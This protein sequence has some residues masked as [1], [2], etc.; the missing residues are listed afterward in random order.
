MICSP[1][2]ACASLRRSPVCE[3][4]SWRGQWPSRRLKI[5]T[6]LRS[7]S[8]TI[9]LLKAVCLSLSAAFRLNTICSSRYRTKQS[10]AVAPPRASGG[11]RRYAW[12]G[13]RRRG[14]GVT[15]LATSFSR[16]EAL[17]E[18][19]ALSAVKTPAS[20]GRDRPCSG[21]AC[22][23]VR[24]V[25]CAGIIRVGQERL[26]LPLNRHFATAKAASWSA[27]SPVVIAGY[28]LGSTSRLERPPA[29]GVSALS[30]D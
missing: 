24:I 3:R 17:D 9:I 2:I 29:I 6:H 13:Q 8:S 16:L 14:H 5:N 4:G 19:E 20:P 15:S 27:L 26:L 21:F 1:R 22:S 10:L 30:P 28:P 18:S 25:A 7:N 11:D 12:S 23:E